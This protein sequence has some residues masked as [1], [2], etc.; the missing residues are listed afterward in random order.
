MQLAGLRAGFWGA[1]TSPQLKADAGRAHLIVDPLNWQDT[2]KALA[3][4]LA[5]PKNLIERTKKIIAA[6]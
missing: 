6:K 1:V 3:E 2:V 4:I 5:T